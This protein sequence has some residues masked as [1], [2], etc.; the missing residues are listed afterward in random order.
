MSMAKDLIKNVED[1]T[2]IGLPILNK[3][4]YVSEKC[5]C[6]Y[7]LD[8]VY[9]EEDIVPIDIGIGHI[10]INIA[11]DELTYKFVPSKSLEKKLIKTFEDNESPIVQIVESKLNK[12]ILETYKELL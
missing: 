10:F 11:D 3:L 1:M 5:I 4:V 12:K 2:Q 8:A 9:E 7:L 6:D